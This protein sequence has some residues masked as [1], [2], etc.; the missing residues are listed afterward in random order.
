MR[1][2][3]KRSLIPATAVFFGFLLLTGRGIGE[4]GA[5]A[6]ARL[7]R[8]NCSI[9]HGEKGD[10]R[11]I[12]AP[13]MGIRIADFT[14]PDFWNAHDDDAIVK[15]ILKGRGRMPAQSVSPE[16]ARAIVQ[17]MTSAFRGKH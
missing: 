13:S 11:G 3:A 14:N 16:E 10:G 7:Y 15:T 4:Q 17:Y 12:A 2:I 5:P 6:G 1:G 9:C 8:A